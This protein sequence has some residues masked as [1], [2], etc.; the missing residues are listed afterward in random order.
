MDSMIHLLSFILIFYRIQEL[1][2]DIPSIPVSAKT[3]CKLQQYAKDGLIVYEQGA[4]NFHI[5]CDISENTLY[6]ELDNVL[7]NILER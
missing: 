7:A 6:S 4:D 1:H 3:E 2:S 5:K